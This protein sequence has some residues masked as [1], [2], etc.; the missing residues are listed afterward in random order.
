MLIFLFFYMLIFKCIIFH[1]NSSGVIFAIDFYIFR[2]RLAGILIN[3][4]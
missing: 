1:I 4:R 2:D 3:M